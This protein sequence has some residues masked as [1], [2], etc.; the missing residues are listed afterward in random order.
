MTHCLFVFLEKGQCCARMSI[1][2]ATICLI[3][4]RWILWLALIIVS[5]TS[6][7]YGEGPLRDK[8]GMCVP[9][10]ANEAAV[11]A[12]IVMLSLILI[13]SPLLIAFKIILICLKCW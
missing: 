7:F 8:N 1:N 13:V 10:E 4:I 5:A 3:I 11:T 2:V 6:D 9:H 12:Q